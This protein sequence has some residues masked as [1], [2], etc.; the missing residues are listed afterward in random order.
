MYNVVCKYSNNYL[1][2]LSEII[3]KYNMVDLIN[4]NNLLKEYDYID[5]ILNKANLIRK[6]PY[7]DILD[8]QEILYNILPIDLLN[9]ID[10]KIE[11]VKQKH[12]L[13]FVW[14]LRMIKTFRSNYEIGYKEIINYRTSED[15]IYKQQIKKWGKIYICYCGGLKIVPYTVPIEYREYANKKCIDCKRNRI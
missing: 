10:D 15:R 8:K 4:M 11:L 9:I 1:L 14:S 3:N 6:Y 13:K 5:N 12:S 7:K 2:E